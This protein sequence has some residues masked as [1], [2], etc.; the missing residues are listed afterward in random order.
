MVVETKLNL[1]T[2]SNFGKMNITKENF[3]KLKQL[4]RIEF[5]QRI[6]LIKEMGKI[7]AK[8][9]FLISILLAFLTIVIASIAVPI[10]IIVSIYFIIKAIIIDKEYSK[11]EEEYFTEEIKIKK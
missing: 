6:L 2:T 5:R 3:D 10:F 4:D 11:L 1:Q 9:Y 8:K 7:N